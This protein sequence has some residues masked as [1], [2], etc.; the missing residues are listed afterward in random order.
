MYTPGWDTTDDSTKAVF[1]D[2]LEWLAAAGVEIVDPSSH[3]AAAQLESDFWL[4]DECVDKILAFEMRWPMQCYL[5]RDDKLLSDK[6]KNRL[7]Q[8]TKMTLDDYRKALAWR[9]QLR[10]HFM[11]LAGLADG[12]VSLA[13]PGPAPLGIESTGDP[14]Y[15]TPSSAVG[16]PSFALPLLAVDGLPQGVQVVGFNDGDDRLAAHCAWLVKAYLEE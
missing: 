14:I 4:A 3:P 9:A 6:I 1:E 15:Q 7:W 16:A 5:D 13:S 8:G 2:F 12:F 11:A 10:N